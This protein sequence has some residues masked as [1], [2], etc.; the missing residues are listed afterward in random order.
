MRKGASRRRTCLAGGQAAP[1]GQRRSLSLCARAARFACVR[2][3]R[4]WCG[5]R[6]KELF[7][8][9]PPSGGRGGRAGGRRRGDDT[10]LLGWKRLAAPL[11]PP[12]GPPF[13]PTG[14]AQK[15]TQCMQPMRPVFISD[16]RGTLD[17]SNFST[18]RS[19]ATQSIYLQLGATL[20]KFQVKEL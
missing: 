1:E 20:Y 17:K 12:R 16:P 13:D 3:R 19:T 14:S 8:R 4:R 10:H 5:E 15:R 2:R 11:L 6:E 9:L 7:A 18:F